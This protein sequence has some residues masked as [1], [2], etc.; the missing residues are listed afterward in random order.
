MHGTSD[1]PAMRGCTIIARNSLPQA[2]VLAS[3]FKEHHP[4]CQFAILV[5]DDLHAT[6]RR[7][8]GIELLALTDIGLE[9]DEAYRMPM[10]CNVTELVTAV[11]PW[12]VRRFLKDETESVIYFDPDIEIFSPLYDLAALARKH[13]IIL[14]PRVTEPIPRDQ[15]RPSESDILG[16]GIYDLG[17]IGLG[18][19][20][21]PFLDWWATPLHC[22]SVSDP[23]G[24]RLSGQRRI[25]FVPSLFPHHVVRDPGVNVAYWNLHSRKLRWEGDRYTVNGKALRFF[26]Y[27]GYDPNKPHLLSKHQGDQP[28]VLLSQHPGVARI[29]HEYRKKLIAAGFNESN[30]NA[31]GFAQLSNGLKIDQHIRKLYRDALDR[32]ERHDGPEPPSP[33]AP[34]GE[35]TFVSWLN[36][37]LRATAPLVT[38]FMLSLHTSR[39]DV[40]NAFPEPLGADAAAFCGWFLQFGRN[41]ARVHDLLLP[42]NAPAFNEQPLSG[43][44]EAARPSQTPRVCVAGYFHAELG[45]GEAARLLVAGLEAANTPY[46]TISYDNTESRQRHPFDEQP[47]EGWPSDINIVCVNADQ[48]PGFVQKMG[49]RFSEGRYRVGVWFWEVEDFPP[50]YHPAF[51]HVDE[52]WVATESMRHT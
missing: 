42:A 36:E 30:R 28:R 35:E 39:G 21:E 10:L 40:Q 23:A 17:F 3:S 22:V 13:S 29:C 31:W 8:D 50:A 27:S 51:E 24:M 9:P 19:G 34:G 6:E 20:S 7:D 25:D 16:A 15:L 49:P 52:I 2:E 5:V 4:D 44:E 18:P 47:G 32:Y 43:I 48:T 45:I 1:R 33:F 14:T 46:R 41:E 37:P 12:L 38:R 26:H 11:K